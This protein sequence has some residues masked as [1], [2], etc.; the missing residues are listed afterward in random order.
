MVPRQPREAPAIGAQARRRVEIVARDEHALLAAFEVYADDLVYGLIPC[1]VLPYGDQSSAVPVDHHVR[2]SPA[3]LRRKRCRLAALG[4]AVDPLVCEVREIDR[5]FIDGEAAATVLVYPRAGIERLWRHVLG[6]SVR[7]QEHDD[8]APA[9]AGTALQP[10][11]VLT[12]ER[13]FRQP[14]YAPDDHIR[15]DRRSPGT[16][17]RDSIFGHSSAPPRCR[18]LSGLSRA[19]PGAS[20]RMLQPGDRDG[21]APT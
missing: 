14:H 4:P 12:V 1:V 3:G 17:G 19:S 9:L 11:H 20:P 8:V 7:R 13:Y 5:A 15:G 6:A 18:G 10:V 2:V 16:V 21:Y